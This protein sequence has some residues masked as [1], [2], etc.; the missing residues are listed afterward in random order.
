MRKFLLVAACGFI[1][2]GLFS[3]SIEDV[4]KEY[5]LGQVKK[6]KEDIDKVMTNAKLNSK[7]EAWVLK[8]AVYANLAG[9]KEMVTQS[10]S[11]MQEALTAFNTY[12]QK[13]PELKLLK[14]ENSFYTNT[15]GT[16]YSSYFNAGVTGYNKKDWPG[17]YKNFKAAVEL[18]DFLIVNKLSNYPIDTNAILLAGASAQNS[19]KADEAAVYYSRLADAK[20]GGSENEFFY[21]Y[22]VEYYMKKG[23]KGQKE[24]Y[25]AIGRQLYPKN[26][27]WCNLPLIEAGEDTLKIMSAYEQM[28]A[29]GSCVDNVTYYDYAREIYNYVNFSKT[30]PQDPAKYETRMIEVL[31][32]SLELKS[33]P[34]ANLLMCRILFFPINQYI[35]DYN[36]VKGT[37]PEDAKK[38]ADINAK[39]NAKYEEMFPYAMA[40]FD[41][42]DGKASL[43]GAEK[44]NFKIVTNMLLE[45][46]TNK[47]DKEKA[48][49]YE[50]KLKEIG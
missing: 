24:K 18:S 7:P 22:L 50:D 9:D 42:Y 27:Y 36:A 48:K 45:Y 29:S 39:L 33:T 34:E 28:I 8:A 26:T 32:K 44:A 23:D 19:E 16:I 43:K 3:Q 37:K 5:I 20:I 35:E 13:D 10:E 41:Y 38:R 15:P 4:Q 47:K 25:L 17:A 1:A 46:W 14:A 2:T 12:K 11:L 21:P 30:K 40:A 49:K 6:A 31:K